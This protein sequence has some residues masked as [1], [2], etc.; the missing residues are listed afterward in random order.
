MSL[1]LPLAGKLTIRVKLLELRTSF[2]GGCVPSL[3]IAVKILRRCSG[4]KLVEESF[5]NS[6][7]Y[8]IQI[9]P[10]KS[11]AAMLKRSTQMCKLQSS[12]L[13]GGLYFLA[14]LLYFF[15]LCLNIC[16]YA[17]YLIKWL[18]LHVLFNYFLFLLFLLIFV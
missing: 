3:S 13:N 15:F 9:A 17:S 12:N 2:H 18:L 14:I 16:I 11:V 5:S 10:E 4:I 6:I 1:S 8:E 7:F